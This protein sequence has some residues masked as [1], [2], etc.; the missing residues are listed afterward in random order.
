[1]K[2]NDKFGFLPDE[3]SAR[4][5]M[6]FTKEIRVELRPLLKA[7]T[8][9]L[10]MKIKAHRHHQRLLAQF[11]ETQPLDLL[12]YRPRQWDRQHHKS[13]APM[14]YTPNIAEISLFRVT[15]QMVFLV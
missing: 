13:V 9:C 2:L 3:V 10:K 8:I 5:A 11:R 1:M 7:K 12:F 6:M 14:E 4:K 15:N